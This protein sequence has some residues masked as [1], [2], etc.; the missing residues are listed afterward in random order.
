MLVSGLI[1]QQ[2]KQETVTKS[3]TKKLGVANGKK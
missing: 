1:P 3:P 2:K